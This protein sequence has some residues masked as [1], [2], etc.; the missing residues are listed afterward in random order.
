MKNSFLLLLFCLTCSAAFAQSAKKGKRLFMAKC[1]SCHAASMNRHLTGPALGPA[2]KEWE[3]YP[4]EDLYAYIRN[5]QK[6]LKE[7]HP[8]AEVVWAD[9][10]PIIMNSFPE[11]TD[12]EIGSILQFIQ[13]R[14]EKD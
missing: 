9:W 14:Y 12:E 6:L 4:K 11:L 5:N 8:R 10:Q 3:K 1:A 7:G 2:L 13:Q